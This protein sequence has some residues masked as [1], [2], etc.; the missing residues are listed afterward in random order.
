MNRNSLKEKDTRYIST[1]YFK[2]HN[3]KISSKTSHYL[4]PVK[5][6]FFRNGIY[7]T[8]F[9]RVN[10]KV[11]LFKIAFLIRKINFMKLDSYLL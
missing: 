11:N 3:V 8:L 6:S 1:G 4:L 9:T 10:V 2:F 7:N 5:S